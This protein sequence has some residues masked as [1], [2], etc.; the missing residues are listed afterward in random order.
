ME[1]IP[2]AR[3]CRPLSAHGGQ[4]SLGADSDGFGYGAADPANHEYT[5]TDALQTALLSLTAL[6]GV[7]SDE[8]GRLVP[9]VCLLPLPAG[10]E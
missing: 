2:A 1:R 4:I 5:A 3:R 7:T 8:T 10:T 6:S 9:V